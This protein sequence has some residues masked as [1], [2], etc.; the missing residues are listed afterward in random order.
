MLYAVLD[1]ALF[2]PN[3]PRSHR[4][5]N[6]I[7]RSFVIK[8]NENMLQ[9][10]KW[11]SLATFTETTQMCFVERGLDDKSITTMLRFQPDGA[12]EHESAL[13]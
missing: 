3:F 2:A 10:A 5:M 12:R 13:R 7:C 6:L 4:L 8:K 11:S 9:K 1:V